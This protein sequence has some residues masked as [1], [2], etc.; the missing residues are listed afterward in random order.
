[1]P[2][3]RA[4]KS[5]PSSA[6]VVP[7]SA[8]VK[9]FPIY[10]PN[11]NRSSSKKPRSY[12]SKQLIARP[13][14]KDLIWVIDDFLSETECAAWVAHGNHTGFDRS[15]LP[16]TRDTAFRDNGRVEIWSDSVADGVWKRLKPFVPSHLGNG[17]ANG[18]YEKIR[19]YRYE[20]GQRFGKH[21][22][23]SVE[24]E[25]K[26]MTGI[27]VLIYL[28]DEGLEGG[29]TV[30]YD[31]RRDERVALSFKPKKGSLL[32]HG[33][34]TVFRILYDTSLVGLFNVL[35]TNVLCVLCDV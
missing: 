31:G 4:D 1:M 2:R 27:T 10:P 34:V 17:E 30:F 6:T 33:Y 32:F 15:Q 25:K 28:N 3:R 19:V 11:A 5:A 7:V 23:E 24:T 9:L 14:Y 18:C 26:S 20:A 22:D 12:P 21:I 16:A 13:L 29:E 35:I 8:P